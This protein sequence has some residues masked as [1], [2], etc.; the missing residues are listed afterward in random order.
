MSVLSQLSTSTGTQNTTLPSWY[1]TAQQKLVSQ[2]QT[3]ASGAPQLQDTAA[4]GAINTLTGANNPF[5]QS[6][7]TLNTIASGGA[8]PFTTNA[9]GQTTPNTST[10]LGGLYAAQQQQLQQ[11]LPT[12]L[13][14]TEAG[15]IGGGNFGSLRGQTANATAEG[16]ALATLQANQ[17]Q[18]AIQNQTNAINAAQQSGALNQ[19]NIADLMNAGQT[20]MTAP[21]TTTANEA[22]IINAVS[23][24]ANVS[25]SQTTTPFNQFAALASSLGSN[26]TVNNLLNSFGIKGGLSSLFSNLGSNPTISAQIQSGKLPITSYDA[27]GNALYTDSSGNTYNSDGVSLS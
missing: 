26:G 5:T 8:N 13:A 10:P 2:A 6:A 15:N 14:P 1:D 24:G 21:F 3:N 4:Q 23:P 11:L 16:N 18:N 25:T 27:N 17:F 9:Q 19:T 22:N 12:T 20:Q 7:N